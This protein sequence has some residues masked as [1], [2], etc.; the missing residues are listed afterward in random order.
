MAATSAGLL[1]QPEYRPHRER[2]PAYRA[3]TDPVGKRRGALGSAAYPARGQ[4]GRIPT[5]RGKITDPTGEGRDR[6]SGKTTV[7]A[8]FQAANS[9]SGTGNSRFASSGWPSPANTDLVGNQYRPLGESIPTLPGESC[10]SLG[11]NL[12]TCAGYF[13]EPARVDYRPRGENWWTNSLQT[14]HFLSLHS[15][16]MMFCLCLVFY[17]VNREDLGG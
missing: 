13:T 2:P 16:Y 7:R 5:P 12:P 1:P 11:E 14:C 6:E 9:P 4:R 15:V 3:N 17:L 10:R 8:R